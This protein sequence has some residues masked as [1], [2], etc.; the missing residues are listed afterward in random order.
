MLVNLQTGIQIKI[1]NKKSN[2]L[3]NKEIE[4]RR[5]RPRANDPDANLFVQI[6]GAPDL[7]TGSDIKLDDGKKIKIT[8]KNA[9][10]IVLA[11]DKVKPQMK[12]QLLALLGKNKQSH[13]RTLSA[14]KR[15]M[16]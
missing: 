10:L 15:S 6:K 5:W 12:T 11:M 8:Q 14:I 7:R 9:K 13:M 4:L 2:L 1:L 3:F 16:T